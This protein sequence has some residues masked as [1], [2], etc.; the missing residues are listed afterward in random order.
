MFFFCCCCCFFHV[1]L[2]FTVIPL[3]GKKKKRKKILM[4]TRLNT[5]WDFP[6]TIVK[7]FP[8]YFLRD[9]KSVSICYCISIKFRFL[10]YLNVKQSKT[11]SFLIRLRFWLSSEMLF[12]GELTL[13]P[14][15]PRSRSCHSYA[16]PPPIKN[17]RHCLQKYIGNKTCCLILSVKILDHV[18]FI[19]L[20]ICFLIRLRQTVHS[21]TRD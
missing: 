2:F 19:I 12:L 10:K 6:F 1:I 21:Y 8:A 17:N 18:I 3:R 16:N 5:V 15:S 9:V 14:A 7:S 13:L 20:E 4:P 11:C